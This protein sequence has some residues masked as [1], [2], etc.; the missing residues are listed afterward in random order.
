MVSEDVERA[1]NLNIDSARA[2]VRCIA[3]AAR[4]ALARALR[5]DATIKDLCA[6]AVAADALDDAEIRSSAMS[7]VAKGILDG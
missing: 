1:I 7:K 5:P 4:A 6:Y 2:R 3:V